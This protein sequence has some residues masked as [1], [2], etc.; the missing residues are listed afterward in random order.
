MVERTFA[1]V[2]LILKFLERIVA[3]C[4]P[5]FAAMKISEGDVSHEIRIIGIHGVRRF[6]A[7]LLS[8]FPCCPHRTAFY[9]IGK[10]VSASARSRFSLTIRTLHATGAV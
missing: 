1:Y 9:R 5:D 6:N 2:H 3:N 10:A 4:G 8:R 7:I